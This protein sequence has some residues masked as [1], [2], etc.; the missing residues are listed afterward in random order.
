MSNQFLKLRRSAVQGKIP[1]TSSLDLGELAINTFDGQLFLKKSGSQ[2]ELVTV[3]G[4]TGSFTG[5]F[6]GNG[7]GL[8]NIPA[9][10]ITGLNLSRIA[11][12][13]I[14]ASVSNTD[15]SGSFRITSGSNTLLNLT[16]DGQL[17]LGNGSFV[18][19]GYQLDVN[20]TVRVNGDIR[21][22]N[23]TTYTDLTADATTG[24][25]LRALIPA[26]FD[27]NIYINRTSIYG[28][29]GVHLSNQTS[30]P[31]PIT[32]YHDLNIR[33]LFSATVNSRNV[34]I[35]TLGGTSSENKFLTFITEDAS[36]SDLAIRF[37]V[38]GWGN[39]AIMG[40]TTRTG[41]N[42][43]DFDFRIGYAAVD[44]NTGTLAYRINGDSGNFII[45]SV[46]TNVASA[47]L[48]VDSTTKGFLPTRTN[49]TASI[50]SPA[51]GLLTY[52]TASG[53]VEGLWQ[54][55]TGSNGW[56]Q[57]L[58]NSS[59]IPASSVVDLNLSR[60][61][62]GSI[63]AS[64]SNTDISASFRLTSGSNTLLNVTRDG[65]VWIGNG[66]VS[67]QAYQLDVNGT[68]R[69]TG[70]LTVN[71]NILLPYVAGS[72]ITVK[73]QFNNR[74]VSI[75]SAGK[76][77]MGESNAS[78][79]AGT[80]SFYYL[81]TAGSIL[82]FG[83]MAAGI[84]DYG[85]AAFH[86]LNNKIEFGQ[87]Y[88]AFSNNQ[89]KVVAEFTSLNN[90]KLY[91]ALAGNYQ[92]GLVMTI[93]GGFS[94]TF[95]D[96][97][98]QGVAGRLI[99]KGGDAQTTAT[100]IN[101]AGGNIEIS[102]GLGTGT[103]IPGDVIFATAAL[104]AS[105]NTLQ[106]LTNR[107]W[108]KGNTGTLTNRGTSSLAVLD[109]SG[110]S[111]FTGSI[112]LQGSL[113]ASNALI[114]GTLT[115]QTLVVQTITSSIIYSSGSNIFGNRLT[116]TQQFTGSVLITGSTVSLIGGSFS[117]SGANLY[118]IPASGITG[119]NLSRIAT[120]SISASVNTDISASFRLTSGSNTL[121][122]V[123]REG[124]VW[125]GNGTF[126]NQAYQLD[127]QGTLRATGDFQLGSSAFI[128]TA[129]GFKQTTSPAVGS[130]YY[131]MYANGDSQRT[132]VQI[133]HR[134]DTSAGLMVGSTT[135]NIS[136]YG[137]GSPSLTFTGGPLKINFKS[138]ANVIGNWTIVTLPTTSNTFTIA[139]N[140]QDYHDFSYLTGGSFFIGGNSGIAN[141]NVQNYFFGG[142]ADLISNS[143][144]A[145]NVTFYATFPSN[146]T[147]SSGG[148]FTI[149]AGRGTGI[150]SA[151]DIIFS[152]AN[153]TGSGT[154]LQALADRWRVKGLT[155]TLS[156]ISNPPS[157]SLYV[158]GSF[159]LNGTQFNNT[160]SLT[161]AGITTVSQLSTSSYTSCFYNYTVASSSNA[162]SGQVMTVWNGDTIRYTE[163]VTT[164]IG[165]TNQVIVSASLSSGFVR[166]QVSAS[167][168]WTFKN[169]SNL[170]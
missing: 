115:A 141:N 116:D 48:N 3:V 30:A 121:L 147:D 14:T 138:G 136:L 149:T 113:T 139:T 60:I 13:S 93:A 79:T 71:S 17:W 163:V 33:D 134:S 112:D 12:G 36:N 114:T 61:A 16:R 68:A 100:N 135:N 43:N 74:D 155:G 52:I 75:S 85:R 35:N 25:I 59:S 27:L 38:N 158:S 122:N 103:G 130:P 98:N 80:Y 8:N 91:G 154:A 109:I 2:G 107:V 20:G 73:S 29:S 63:T 69:I 153:I 92:G 31:T 41:R 37:R 162:R 83:V 24:K 78:L 123:T 28:G 89:Q 140:I 88:Q 42:R 170:L 51:Q 57:F 99:L 96:A 67:N 148:N 76:I 161:V 66:A 21:T 120:G 53:E 23:G 132:G 108:I 127:V 104:T 39:S 146:Q 105:G 7:A 86:V 4:S 102:G 110:S 11:T 40:I 118:N 164:D 54:Y 6:T 45:G 119:L 1:E 106:S 46:G 94:G 152:T 58:H 166:L 90:W 81:P 137:V 169:I 97:N 167:S 64:V 131:Y 49:T 22:Q 55:R 65:F 18:N 19:Q 15:I 87:T 56:V 133:E 145:R 62:T 126:T 125:I 95:S 10:G 72:T 117:G 124:L 84:E 144:S 143:Q 34:N 5:S 101:T 9:S 160:S 159:I 142:G 77:T 168:G 82:G 47:I 150:G 157:A 111:I 70:Q 128:G 32:G 50:T 165:N 44:L 26:I 151:G 156:N 129:V